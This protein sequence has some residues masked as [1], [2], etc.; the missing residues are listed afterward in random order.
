MNVAKDRQR[1]GDN[2]K[3][4]VTGK[5]EYQ[6]KGVTK[7]EEQVKKMKKLVTKRKNR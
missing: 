6:R 4:K 1:I 3:N 5:R 7:K 2:R